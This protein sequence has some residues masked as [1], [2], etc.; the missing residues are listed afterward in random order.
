MYVQNDAVKKSTASAFASAA[1]RSSPLRGRRLLSSGAGVGGRRS[2]GGRVLSSHALSTAALDTILAPQAA[3]LPA[4]LGTVTVKTGGI[5]L[6]LL[7]GPNQ[8]TLVG[9]SDFEVMV[10]G[11]ALDLVDFHLLFSN[12]EGFVGDKA[13]PALAQDFPAEQKRSLFISNLSFNLNYLFCSPADVYRA[14]KR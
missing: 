6:G 12:A 11:D 1:K 4:V 9:L 14:A 7:N 3:L 2:G 10:L 8:F 13:D 5:T